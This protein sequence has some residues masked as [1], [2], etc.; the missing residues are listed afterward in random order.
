[1]A[2]VFTSKLRAGQQTL[3][4]VPSMEHVRD[5]TRNLS[6]LS[7]LL[8]TPPCAAEDRVRTAIETYCAEIREL[9]S[10]LAPRDLEDLK[11]LAVTNHVIMRSFEPLQQILEADGD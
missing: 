8:L 7:D 11:A 6:L 5:S 1:M 4:G 3:N 2:Q 10:A 9:V